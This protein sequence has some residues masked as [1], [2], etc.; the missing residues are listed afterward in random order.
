MEEDENW[1]YDRS[2]PVA[3][4]ER[5]YTNYP[6]IAASDATHEPGEE[7]HEEDADEEEI[8]KLPSFR[9]GGPDVDDIRRGVLDLKRRGRRGLAGK[10]VR[11]DE[12]RDRIGNEGEFDK[13]LDQLKG[14]V[15]GLI[16]MEEMADLFISL[17]LHYL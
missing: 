16:S 10:K 6:N 11:R 13:I 14:G 2:V 1:K 15:L 17:V 8:R 9:Y 3:H 5:G 7:Y 4:I 12:C